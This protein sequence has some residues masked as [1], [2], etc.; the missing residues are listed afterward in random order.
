MSGGCS[1]LSCI[2][3][4]MRAWDVISPSDDTEVHDR[5]E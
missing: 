4:Y 3:T 1:I 2:G 5:I